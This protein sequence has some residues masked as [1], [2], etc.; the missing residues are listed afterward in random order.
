MGI[1]KLLDVL[2]VDKAGSLQAFVDILRKRCVFLAV[3]AVPVVELNVK[4]VQVLLA[5][6]SD[7]GNKL[8][9]RDTFFLRSNHNRGAVRIIG[10]DKVHL[11]AAH[12]FVTNPNIGLNVFHNVP[13]MKRAVCI[14]QGGCH[15]NR[16]LFLCHLFAFLIQR[17]RQESR[18]K[19]IF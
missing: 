15:E 1:E 16:S 5:T 10:S 8:L 6:G 7:F 9:R 13:D 3:R 18:R 14:G 11:V 12:A 17:R 2:G 19:L 4:A